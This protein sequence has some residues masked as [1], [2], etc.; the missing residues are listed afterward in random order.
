MCSLINLKYNIKE[1]L[2]NVVHYP[3]LEKGSED[4]RIILS[5]PNTHAL[6][7]V[8]VMNWDPTVREGRGFHL[9]KSSIAYSSNYQVKLQHVHFFNPFKT[10]IVC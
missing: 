4:A 7:C 3:G 8:A 9:Q 6:F 1:S 5:M 10:A 2:L